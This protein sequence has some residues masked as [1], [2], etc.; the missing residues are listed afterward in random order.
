MNLLLLVQLGFVIL[1]IVYF[2]IF[3]KE[4][5]KGIG[6]C[7][8][9]QAKKKRLFNIIFF[10]LLGW[11]VFVSIWSLSGVM[12]NFNLFPFNF[13]PVIA[14]PLITVVLILFSTRT[15]EILRNIPPATLIRIQSFRFFVEILL[16]A[17][18]AISIVP[19]QMTF[20]GRNFDVL[21]GLS[22]PMIAS[23]VFQKK[24]SRKVLIA[25]NLLCLGLL[26]NIVAVA[27]LSTPSPWRIFM[28]E[29]ANTIVTV[30]PVSFL[31]GLLVPL[32]YSLH[33]FSFKQLLSV[34]GPDL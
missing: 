29:P 11:T 23:L 6:D 12:S 28:D 24:I 26:I 21:T 33:F 15:T 31:P 25:W 20:E 1:T 3:L 14:I 7:S 18:F 32:A 13:M 27:I 9:D 5:K 19:E 16:W 2:W 34:K 8:W 10:S 22:A 30:F 17:L 4:I